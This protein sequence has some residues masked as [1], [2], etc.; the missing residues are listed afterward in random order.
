MR[1]I[2]LVPSGESGTTRYR[3]C[4]R[5][6]AMQGYK[7]GESDPSGSQ[8]RGNFRA[9]SP[10][11]DIDCEI[12]DAHSLVKGWSFTNNEFSSYKAG[13]PNRRQFSA[14]V[15]SV[16][17]RGTTRN[18]EWASLTNTG[19]SS[20]YLGCP[21]RREFSASTTNKRNNERRGEREVGSLVSSSCR[22]P[23]RAVV[24]ASRCSSQSCWI[25]VSGHTCQAYAFPGINCFPPSELRCSWVGL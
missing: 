16:C 15:I 6:P 20:S 17:M 13:T 1:P 19:G 25:F 5:I 4:S 10:G 23:R 14:R 8:L 24:P 9:T 2:G 11:D 21:R 3:V 7:E 18:L 12:K 22:N